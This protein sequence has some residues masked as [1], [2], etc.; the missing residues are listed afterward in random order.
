MTREELQAKRD[1]IL[2]RINESRIAFGDRSVEYSEA[3]KALA[4]L[5]AEIARVDAASASSSRFR[6]SFVTF[7]K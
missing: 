1:E 5:D 7:S 3:S 4:V 2:S 6:T